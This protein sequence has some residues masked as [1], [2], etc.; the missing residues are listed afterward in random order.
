[1]ETRVAV[2]AIIVENKESVNML[3][4]ILH[5][6]GKYIISRMGMPY[7]KRDVNIIS[8]AIDAPQDIISALTGKIGRLNGVS[9][10]TAYSNVT[11]KE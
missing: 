4:N 8:I 5:E 2:V 3:N 10:K 11:A 7:P 9:A 1:M 6:Y